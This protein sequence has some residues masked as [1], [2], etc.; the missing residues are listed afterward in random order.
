MSVIPV[1]ITQSDLQTVQRAFLLSILGG[2]VQVVEGRQNRVS[3]V[4]A[5]DFVVMLKA[6]R[7][8]LSTNEDTWDTADPTPTILDVATPMECRTQLD[9]HGPNSSDNAHRIAALWRDNV[10]TA[11][12][13]ASGFALAPLWATEPRYIEFV[14][15]SAQW[16]DRW[17]VDAYTQGNFVL[18]VPQQF[19]NTANV[20]IV[21]LA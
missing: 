5:A 15:D 20:S 14:N 8:Q 19:A 16:E 18:D 13:A 10:A 4:P 21:E 12:F 6:V 11:F 17:I 1:S 3:E 2:S 7:R 9:V